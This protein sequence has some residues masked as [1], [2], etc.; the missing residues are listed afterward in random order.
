LRAAL[1]PAKAA[2]QPARVVVASTSAREL[3][4]RVG[5]LVTG[6]LTCALAGALWAAQ[7]PASFRAVC[8]LDYGQEPVT[9]AAGGSQRAG[10]GSEEWYR[11]Q[12]VVLASHVLAERVVQT[13][14]LDRDRTFAG[15]GAP[16]D[17]EAMRRDAASAL[18]ARLSITPL[19][20]TRVVRVAVEDA[21]PKR[22]ASIA[23]AV[24]DAYLNKAV[25]DRVAG[26]E[27]AL[28]W[29]SEQI[30]TTSRRLAD[31]EVEIQTYLERQEGPALAP[32]DR[33][34]VLTDEI[35][36]LTQAIT[37]ARLERIG[38][39]AR[40]AK[41]KSAAQTDNPFDAHTQEIDD[42]D[43]VKQL[44]AA[45]L[46]FV[47]ERESL[48]AGQPPGEPHQPLGQKK[49]DALWSRMQST[50]DGIVRSAQA[51][52]T[53]VQQV[54]TQLESALE[55]ANAAGHALQRQELEYGRLNRERAEADQWLKALRERSS[56]AGA[57]TAAGMLNARVIDPAVPPLAPQPPALLPGAALGALA[58]TLLSSLALLL[59]SRA[60]PACTLETQGVQA[61]S[62]HAPG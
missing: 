52:L 57:A 14:H 61:P 5:W 13:L 11:T 32:E 56:A 9:A 47:L 54:E 16:R 19:P 33:Q 37:E 3:R 4:K 12:D 17:P 21:D 38:L 18:R 10:P 2:W 55:R 51:E 15:S 36:R 31:T 44:R 23:N 60:R 53:A 41:L 50:L 29:L 1:A 42:S 45:Y 59:A 40:V 20:Q 22:A 48:P 25:E 26:T 46:S 6:A 27:R 58:G 35:K 30:G 8:V 7:Q 39:S 62:E 49:L 24:V 28:A 34:A 43:E